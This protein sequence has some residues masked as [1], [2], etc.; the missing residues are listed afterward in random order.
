MSA[1]G[2]VADTSIEEHV[3]MYDVA[4]LIYDADWEVRG[5]LND[6]VNDIAEHIMVDEDKIVEAIIKAVREASR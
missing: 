2:E 3:L 5:T 1:Q 6:R 4:Q